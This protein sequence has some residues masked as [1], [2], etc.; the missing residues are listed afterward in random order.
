[1]T[2]MNIL[3]PKEP[4]RMTRLYILRP[5]PPRR[6]DLVEWGWRWNPITKAWENPET[7]EQKYTAA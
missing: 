5:S 6:R 1:M 7:S 4:K 2:A 3:A